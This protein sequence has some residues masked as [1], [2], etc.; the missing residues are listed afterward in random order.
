YRQDPASVEG[1]WRED[2]D[3]LTGRAAPAPAA[4]A[5]APEPTPE[6]PA[7]EQITLEI[8]DDPPGP[9]D[10]AAAAPAPA[11]IVRAAPPTLQ[12][13]AAPER[14]RALARPALMPGDI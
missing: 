13:T 2:F 3:R 1:S 9:A 6:A 10:G 14:S 12:R 7:E 5:G 4:R 11:P 8:L